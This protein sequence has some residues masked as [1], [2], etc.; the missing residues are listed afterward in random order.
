MKNKGIIIINAYSPSP[1]RQALRIKE[2][3]GYLGVD[4]Q[5]IRNDGFLTAIEGGKISV[6]QDLDFC[7]YLDKDKYVSRML[8]NSGI[9]L[10]NSADAVE[11]CDDKMTTHIMLANNGINMPDTLP[12]LLCY[13]NGAE[14][15]PAVLDEVERRLGYPVVVKRS[16]GSLGSGVFKADDR[17]ELENIANKLKT[18]PHLFQ[19]FV[20]DSAGKDMRVIVVGHSVVGG[21]L[22][23]S[24][25]DFRSNIGLGG[26][27]RHVDVPKDVQKTALH[28]ADILGL[29]YC[30]I[31]FLISDGYPV[32]EVNSNAFFDAF[33]AATNINVA[34]AYAKHI[35]A[36]VY[37]RK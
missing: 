34:G 2:E 10:F 35:V 20:A 33:E 29:D 4:A 21:I 32:C 22:R 6:A 24:T 19:K 8:E 16:Y 12:G 13:D 18:E 7:V 27:A 31:D 37:G 30:G 15:A 17:A 1:T 14:T 26:S 3:L 11:N 9:R 5:I 25:S 23:C 28:I 36:S